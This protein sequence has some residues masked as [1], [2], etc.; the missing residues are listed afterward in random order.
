M[1]TATWRLQMVRHVSGPN[2][3][4]PLCDYSTRGGVVAKTMT[5]P[6]IVGTMRM[7]AKAMLTRNAAKL[8][9]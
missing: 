5:L 2:V 1:A 9:T 6:T 4:E 8:L 3:C 7:R